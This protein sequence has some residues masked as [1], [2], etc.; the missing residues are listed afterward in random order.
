MLPSSRCVY[1]LILDGKFQWISWSTP[2]RHKHMMSGYY[3]AHWHIWLLN[4]FLPLTSE[5]KL[6]FREPSLFLHDTILG[7]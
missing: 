2:G 6:F 5:P 3:Q 4:V 1:N 7:F